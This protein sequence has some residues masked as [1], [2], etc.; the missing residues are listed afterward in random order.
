MFN[1]IN[2]YFNKNKLTYK[3]NLMKAPKKKTSGLTSSDR[4]ANVLATKKI[5]ELKNN[6]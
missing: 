3:T 6:Q 5:R 1:L 4:N 2:Y